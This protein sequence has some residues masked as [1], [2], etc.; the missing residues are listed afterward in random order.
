MTKDPDT[1]VTGA[2]AKLETLDPT[3]PWYEFLSYCEACRSLNV[4]ASVG[5]FTRYQ[6]YIR[7]ISL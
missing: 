1:S 2:E 7:T 4:K 3:T 6:N 5:R